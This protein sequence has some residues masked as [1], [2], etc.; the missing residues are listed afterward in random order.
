MQWA[1]Y[2]QFD[3]SHF[4]LEI[5]RPPPL[6]SKLSTPATARFFLANACKGRNIYL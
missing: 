4:Q 5:L 1:N 2:F 6:L 3:G